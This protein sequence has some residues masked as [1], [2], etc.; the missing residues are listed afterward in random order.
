MSIVLDM[1]SARNLYL[2]L[3]FY[4]QKFLLVVIRL[5]VHDRFR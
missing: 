1:C 5:Q 3:S 2:C 4:S